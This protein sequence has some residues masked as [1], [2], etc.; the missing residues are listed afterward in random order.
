MF[1]R[2]FEVALP[3]VDFQ[4]TYA[5]FLMAGAVAFNATSRRNKA[6][7]EDREWRAKLL[8]PRAHG[9]SEANLSLTISLED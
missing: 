3:A 4:Q 1:K 7:R 9:G 5:G 8:A 6:P 2:D